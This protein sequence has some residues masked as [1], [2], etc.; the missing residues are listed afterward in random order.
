MLITYTSGD[1]VL[2]SSLS[3]D[4]TAEAA[5]RALGLAPG[6]WR[7]ITE[8]EAAELQKP[9]PEELAEQRKTEI[10]ARLDALDLQ[11]MRSVRALLKGTATDA[12][13]EKLAELEAEAAGLR[14]E[15]TGLME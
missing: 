3:P 11:S 15:L 2:V 1:K 6:T 13:T 12:D 9:T 10:R 7:E 5:A 4:I 14:A 8:E